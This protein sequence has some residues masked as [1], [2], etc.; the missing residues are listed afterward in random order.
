[1]TKTSQRLFLWLSIVMLLLVGSASAAAQEKQTPW[2][3][4]NPNP[5]LIRRGMTSG[6][7]N[8]IWD[9]GKDH[10]YAEL[11]VRVDQNDE[12]KIMERGRGG[13]QATVELGKSYVFKL[14]DSNKLL[15]SVKV[16]AM[17]GNPAPSPTPA[18]VGTTPDYQPMYAVNGTIRWRKD[19]GVVPISNS[20]QTSINDRCVS[21]FVAAVDPRTN[22]P[23]PGDYRQMWNGDDYRDSAGRTYYTCRYALKLP[24]NRQVRVIGGLGGEGLLPQPDPNPMF[25]TAQWVGGDATQ[26][27]PPAGSMRMLSGSRYVTLSQS[28]PRATV[29]VELIYAAAPSGNP[30]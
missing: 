27:H 25:W 12:T 28:A 8:L 10:P 23:I 17:R 2:L 29:D 1:M 18:P 16:T 11:W 19:Y 21:F 7:V 22:Q 6:T 15:A 30:K 5:V 24:T 14:S 9:G 20:L 13:Y 3:E 26:S 4:A